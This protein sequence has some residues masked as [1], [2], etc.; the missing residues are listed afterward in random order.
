MLG[1]QPSPQGLTVQVQQIATGQT[2]EVSSTAEPS[3]V[4]ER[5]RLEGIAVPNLAQA[6]WGEAA[7]AALEKW[8]QQQ[9]VLMESDV[10]A[11]D[12]SGQRLAYLWRNGT[13]VNEQLVAEGW[14]IAQPHPPNSRYDARLARA[15]DRARALGLGIW[16]PDRP[17]R[18]LAPG[19]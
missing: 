17:L 5:V 10:Q 19:P 3:E 11:R 18:Q 12:A 8:I 13:L 1:C 4:T 16:D 9:A 6:P 2:L 7:K 14:A 15:Q